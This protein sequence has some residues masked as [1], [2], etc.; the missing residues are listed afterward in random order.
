[1]LPN[2]F[3]HQEY[4]DA[5]EFKWFHVFENFLFKKLISE[6]MRN[7]MRETLQHDAYCLASLFKTELYVYIRNGSYLVFCQKFQV[8]SP[9]E[10]YAGRPVFKFTYLDPVMIS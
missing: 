8:T 7:L 5:A 1:M 3:L 2:S 10:L 6:T 4:K 9:T